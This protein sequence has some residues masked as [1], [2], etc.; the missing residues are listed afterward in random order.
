VPSYDRRTNNTRVHFRLVAEPGKRR[1]RQATRGSR[2]LWQWP[3][4][5]AVYLWL[6]PEAAA[7]PAPGGT[8]SWTAPQAR[9][10]PHFGPACALGQER[11][12]LGVGKNVDQDGTH[13]LA[14]ACRELMTI[15]CACPAAGRNERTRSS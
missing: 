15:I 7:V 4:A 9:N 6:A 13:R 10:G 8:R 11:R 14:S 1:G 5:L 3:T 12:R 2:V